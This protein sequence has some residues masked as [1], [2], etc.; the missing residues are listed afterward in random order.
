MKRYQF[1]SLNRIIARR[2]KEKL[3]TDYTAPVRAR[4]YT[5]SH[6]PV[7][8]INEQDKDVLSVINVGAYNLHTKIPRP[9][10]KLFSLYIKGPLAKEM[11]A[12]VSRVGRACPQLS[13]TLHT[14][15]LIVYSAILNYFF[16]SVRHRD[17]RWYTL[18][19]SDRLSVLSPFLYLY[20][21]FSLSLSIGSF[22]YFC[23]NVLSH[24]L[25][26]SRRDWNAAVVVVVASCLLADEVFNQGTILRFPG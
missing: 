19:S 21:S 8:L 15:N 10:V 2:R 9:S 4:R 26:L 18:K 23:D 17:S 7:G 1:V 6:S 20:L 22:V 12:K 5:L 13:C 3:A 25:P 11:E 16:L 24:L 14:R